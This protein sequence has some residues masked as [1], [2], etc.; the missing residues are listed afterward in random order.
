MDAPRIVVIGLGYVGLPLS[1]L[2]SGEGFRV[3]GFDIAQDK[4]EKLLTYFDR[5]ALIEVT[6]DLRGEEKKAEILVNA[7]HKHDFVA[8]AE[9]AD[10]LVAVTEAV[11]RMKQ[12]MT[13]YKERVQDHRRN[14]SHG[15]EA[16]IKP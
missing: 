12:Q 10:L 15:G 4:V 14:P 8:R 9:H 3:T 11:N 7:E 2:F 5:V 16:G 1:L 13:H 6:I